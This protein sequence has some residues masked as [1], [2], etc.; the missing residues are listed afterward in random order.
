MAATL[1][2]HVEDCINE[3]RDGTLTE[4]SLRRILD[5]PDASS[6]RRQRLLYLQT[7]TTSATS[8]ILGMAMMPMPKNTNNGFDENDSDNWPYASVLEA[9]EDGWRVISFPDVSLLMDE[10]TP[11]GLGC[12]FVLEKWE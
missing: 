3:L 8:A 4:A 2:E 1:R 9:M 12:E 10:N 6:R 7:Q 5:L 11:T